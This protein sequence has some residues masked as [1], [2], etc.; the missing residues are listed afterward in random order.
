[1]GSRLSG[2]WALEDVI[3]GL[4]IHIRA[5]LDDGSQKHNTKITLRKKATLWLYRYVCMYASYGSSTTAHVSSNARA[6]S[7]Q[8]RF[9]LQR[10]HLGVLL[11]LHSEVHALANCL[12]LFLAI[13]FLFIILNAI[14]SPFIVFIVFLLL[15]FT[16]TALLMHRCRSPLSPGHDVG[17]GVSEQSACRS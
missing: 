2:S 1:M 7:V 14:Y 5:M 13:H 6:G 17:R 15:H 9:L 11:H 16:A 12:K 3:I 10:M 8:L 4:Y